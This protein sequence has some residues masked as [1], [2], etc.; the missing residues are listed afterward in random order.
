LDFTEALWAGWSNE[1]ICGFGN[2]ASLIIA[3]GD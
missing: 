2:L 3:E 1:T